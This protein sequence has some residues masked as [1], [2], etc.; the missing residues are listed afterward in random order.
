MQTITT[1]QAVY[2]SLEHVM[3]PEIPVLNVLELGMITDVRVDLEGVHIKMIPTFA[4]CPAVDVIRE[5]ITHTV[6]R[7]LQMPAFVSVD[8]EVNWNS[9]RLTDTAKEKLRD[10]GIAP[11][12]RHAGDVNL[13]MLIKV[14]CPH[15]N[16]E[17][18]YLR[19]PF[20]STLCRALHF[21]KECGMMFE[22]FKPLS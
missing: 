17:N 8:K 3:D 15:C 12:G 1:L 14:T 2:N 9:N 20:G 19:S 13:D 18:T 10:F 7:D 22:Q 4:A 16:S 11:P 5:N 6:E 21:C